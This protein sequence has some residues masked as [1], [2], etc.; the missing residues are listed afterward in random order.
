MGLLD[1]AKDLLNKNKGK[2]PQGVDKATDVVDQKTGG[3][4]RDN[5]EKVDDAARKYAG[6]PATPASP[7]ADQPGTPL[8]ADAPATASGQPAPP[9]PGETTPKT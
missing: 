9:T 5:L 1:K 4:H 8:P 6:E 2:V 7:A 3:K